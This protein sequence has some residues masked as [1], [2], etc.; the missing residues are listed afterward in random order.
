MKH[1]VMDVIYSRAHS[2]YVPTE[3]FHDEINLKN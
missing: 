1:L 3:M 2:G